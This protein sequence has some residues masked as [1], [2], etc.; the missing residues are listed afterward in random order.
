MQEEERCEVAYADY[1]DR[2]SP[3]AHALYDEECQEYSD[4]SADR[5][6]PACYWVI[7]AL[8]DELR[9]VSE[10]HQV[11]AG[12]HHSRECAACVESE[13][14]AESHARCVKTYTDGHESAE[15]EVSYDSDDQLDAAKACSC[16]DLTERSYS[17]YLAEHYCSEDEHTYEESVSDL[18]TVESGYDACSEVS[19]CDGCHDHGYECEQIHVRNEVEEQECLDTN[20]NCVS[21]VQSTR[22][23]YVVN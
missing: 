3:E 7:S 2:Q 4:S 6:C 22:D 5:L 11:S 12:S 1:H 16:S 8:L 9:T 19:T 23:E 14:Y 20:R 18:F 10:C 21:Y 17:E 13:Q 15:E